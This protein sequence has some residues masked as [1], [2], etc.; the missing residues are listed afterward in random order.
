MFE[1]AYISESCWYQI[2]F[3]MLIH[4]PRNITTGGGKAENRWAQIRFD[5][6]SRKPLEF[7]SHSSLLVQFCQIRGPPVVVLAGTLIKINYSLNCSAYCFL[8]VGRWV[9]NACKACSSISLTMGTFVGPDLFKLI[10][11]TP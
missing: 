4:V 1:H 8:H 9:E 6:T 11:R 2:L 10:S 3:P 5:H 7:G